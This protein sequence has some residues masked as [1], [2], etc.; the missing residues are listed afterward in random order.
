MSMCHLG[1]EKNKQLTDS[2][3]EGSFLSREE[4]K[5]IATEEGRTGGGI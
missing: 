2:A 4:S 5:E 3:R 1:K